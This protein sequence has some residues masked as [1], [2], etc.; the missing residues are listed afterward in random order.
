MPPARFA[1]TY[2]M[3]RSACLLAAHAAGAQPIDTLEQDF[4]NEAG[5]VAAC[6]AARREGF[7]GKIAIHPAQVGPINAGFRPTAEEI[8]FARKVADL[9]AANPGIGTIGLEGKMLDMPH[10]RQAQRVLAADAAFA[11]R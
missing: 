11:G 5:C 4:R 6:A 2:R 8:A 9:F 1:L 7:T 3:A 10:L